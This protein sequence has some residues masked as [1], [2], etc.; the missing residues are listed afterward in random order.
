MGRIVPAIA[1]CLVF[2][3]GDQA[4]P[5][6]PTPVSRQVVC[7]TAYVVVRGTL[8][9]VVQNTVRTVLTDTQRSVIL[10]T[11][12]TVLLRVEWVPRGPA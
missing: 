1:A 9:T 11:V 5:P 7:D 10:A 8:R 2:A 3:C 6:A 4:P 12:R